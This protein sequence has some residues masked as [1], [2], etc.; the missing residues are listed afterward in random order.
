MNVTNT[1]RKE[2]DLC[3]YKQKCT[4]AVKRE[5]NILTNKSH[6]TDKIT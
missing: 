5:F 1:V 4:L 6:G 3:R 2:T